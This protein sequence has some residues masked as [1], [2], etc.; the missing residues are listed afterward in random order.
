MTQN[1]IKKA[2]LLFVINDF[3]FFESHRKNLIL[4]LN[5]RGLKVQVVTNLETATSNDLERYKKIGV[6][7]IDFKF[8]R[9][10]IGVFSNINSLFRL[11]LILKK[12]KPNKISLV[13][14][15]PIVYGGLCAA[16]L[17]FDKVF[18]T[19]SGLGYSFISD[20]KKAI[21]VSKVIFKIYKFIFSKSNIK[22]IFQNHDDL[23]FFI[24][25]QLLSRDKALC[26]QG[27]GISLEDFKREKYP[28]QLSFLFASRLLTDKGI[29]EYIR[30][31]ENCSD[32]GAIFQVAGDIDLDNPNSL[33]KDQLVD[34]T[35][36]QSI[37]YLGNIE[38][39]TMPRVF[40][41]AH[42]L[43]LPSY[44]EGLPKVALEAAASGMPLILSDVNGCRDCL[45]N[46]ET[47]FLT[48]N[49]NSRDLENKFKY[50]INNPEKVIEMGSASR[51]HVESFFSEEVIF[52]KFFKIYS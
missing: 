10:S 19:I 36:N 49:K 43:V 39:K 1:H 17:R 8:N 22:V 13:S 28:D 33:S 16:V 6:D 12:Y 2:D 47:G 24:K 23:S 30:A 7:L 29:N 42:I 9:S 40:N 34:L 52:N 15:K 37:D 25:N 38:Y 31:A 21:F 14:S 46:G 18:Y 50:F 32:L 27:N 41:E 35:N 3:K 48:E 20:S 26:I 51:R 11:F 4:D 45:I 44:R 5:S